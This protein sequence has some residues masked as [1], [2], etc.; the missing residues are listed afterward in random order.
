[1]RIILLL[2]KCVKKYFFAVC[3]LFGVSPIKII[4]EDMIIIISRPTNMETKSLNI[5][6]DEINIT[7]ERDLERRLFS[8]NVKL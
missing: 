5:G 2:I 8:S 4:T 1:M 3:A 6:L 7:L